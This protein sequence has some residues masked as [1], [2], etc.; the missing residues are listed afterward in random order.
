MKS[1]RLRIQEIAWRNGQRNP[2]FAIGAEVTVARLPGAPRG[3]VIAVYV[4]YRAAVDLGVII[5]DWHSLQKPPPATLRSG[6]WY[7]VLLVER[8]IF[9]GQDDLLASNVGAA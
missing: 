2:K 1:N 3:V 6:V 7:S 9:Q 5:D 8:V 4:D